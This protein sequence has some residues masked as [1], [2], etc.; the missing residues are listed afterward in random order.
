MARSVQPDSQK[1]SDSTLS[2]HPK[3]GFPFLFHAFFLSN[4]NF[5][6]T[7]TILDHTVDM[8]ATA[9]CELGFT[10]CKYFLL[11]VS[12]VRIAT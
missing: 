4:H 12:S 8:I 6:F 9:M 3:L 1:S 10:Y 2:A 5:K 11:I 7:L